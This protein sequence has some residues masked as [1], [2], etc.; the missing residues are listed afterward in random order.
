VTG[1]SA[2]AQGNRIAVIRDSSGVIWHAG[3]RTSIGGVEQPYFM[4]VSG[5]NGTITSSD[6][7]TGTITGKIVGSAPT[8]I[9]MIADYRGVIWAITADAGSNAVSIFPV[10]TVSG[11]VNSSNISNANSKTVRAVGQN[12]ICARFYQDAGN[13]LWAYTS[14][15]SSGSTSFIPVVT[16]T[17]VFTYNVS[18]N[19][20]AYYLTANNIAEI[21][22]NLPLYDFVSGIVPGGLSTYV[23][24]RYYTYSYTGDPSSAGTLGSGSQLRFITN[25]ADVTGLDLTLASGSTL[26][27]GKK[28]GPYTFKLIAQSDSTIEV[29]PDSDRSGSPVNLSDKTINS[30]VTINAVS[31]SATVQVASTA[32][33]TAGAGVTLFVLNPIQISVSDAPIGSSIG[34]FKS[35]GAGS[36]LADRA[37]FTLASGNNSG[38]ST[39]VI[40]GSIPKDTPTAGYVRVVRVDG[41]EDR[42]QYTSW[43]G[44]TF[45]LSGGVTLPISYSAGL[46]CYVGYLDVINSLSGSESNTIQYVADRYCVYTVIKGSGVGKIQPI[47]QA[48]TLQ[49]QDSVIPVAGVLDSI[50]M[51]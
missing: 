22:S 15:S 27:I 7:T 16:G 12:P 35:T 46:G 28:V 33:I 30:G 43:S 41:T 29:Y 50:N 23:Y 24:N 5:A 21:S 6:I 1:A 42:L 14:N 38:N 9:D 11:V 10:A 18:Q 44:S 20:G 37:Q 31:G 49:N 45:T 8:Y 34:V 36:L 40:S 3:E 48:F 13:N 26:R 32:G 51:R 25:T 39:L 17:P 4:P 2:Q 19:S 47:R